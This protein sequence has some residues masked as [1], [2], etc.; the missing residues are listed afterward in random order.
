MVFDRTE[1]E[2][3]EPDP[4]AELEDP[5]SDSL[6]I[7]RVDTEDA[8]LGLLSDLRSEHDSESAP[9]LGVSTD[10][11]D[12]PP[13]LARIFWALVLVINAAVLS[14]SLGVLF[15]IFDGITTRSIALI[16]GGVVLFGF[17]VYR[18]RAFRADTDDPT[19]TAP[20]SADA[21]DTE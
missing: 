7:P 12:V 17:A 20:D 10:E 15:A 21:D 16:A 4:E 6:T 3:E 2:P 8:G 11:V 13:D 18:Y 5:E 1:T 19:E 9:D 14:V